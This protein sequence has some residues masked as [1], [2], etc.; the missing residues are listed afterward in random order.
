MADGRSM[1]HPKKL[2]SLI[3]NGELQ[4]DTMVW[5]DGMSGWKKV[6]DVPNLKQFLPEDD[7]S[8][9]MG[10]AM[11]QAAET[12]QWYY[13]NAQQEQQGPFDPSVVRSLIAHGTLQGDTLLWCKDM[14]ETWSPIKDLTDFEQDLKRAKENPKSAGDG[15]PLPPA[16]TG[17]YYRDKYRAQKGPVNEAALGKLMETKE[18]TGDSLV[19]KDGMKEWSAINTLPEL[20][21]L[22]L[23]SMLPE[24]ARMKIKEEEEKLALSG[25]GAGAAATG[26]A[27]TASEENAKEGEDEKAGQKRK[28]KKKKTKKWKKFENTPHVYVQGLPPDASLQ[29]I[30]DHFKKAGL[31]VK[32]PS[33]EPKI[34]M[35]KDKSGKP[36]GDGLVSYMKVESVPLAIQFLHE[37]EI[38]P[39][40][41]LTVQKAEFQQKGDKFIARKKTKTDIKFQKFA[42]QQALDWDEDGLREIKGF[43]IVILMYMFDPKEAGPEP[44]KFYH[45]LKVEVGM[46]VEKQCGE[47]EKLTVFEHNPDGVIAVKF[48]SGASA[49]KCIEIMDGRFFGQ[50]KI[51]CFYFDGKTNYKVEESEES[52]KKRDEEYQK[53]MMGEQDSKTKA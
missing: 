51:K 26:A 44:E 30:H 46:E 48:K 2:Q 7:P 40:F 41:K 43:R 14:G 35:Y 33:G 16:A 13:L 28:R 5:A 38:R 10:A 15:K 21:T 22:A 23:T 29:E 31:I 36:K 9:S 17:W 19:W 32:L 12:T 24:E 3:E 49:A 37:S 27:A 1:M 42:A 53:W 8:L 11:R 20:A 47:I 50:R 39:G 34:K 52:R 45:E 6:N 25:G 4:G 18:L